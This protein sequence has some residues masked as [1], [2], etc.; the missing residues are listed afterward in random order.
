MADSKPAPLSSLEV[1]TMVSDGR[2]SSTVM[3][4]IEHLD[5]AE[6]R[7]RSVHA[8]PIGAHLEFTVSVHGA[9][10]IPLRGEI[11]AS[12]QNGPRFAYVV[13]LRNA[14]E[15]TEAI[16]KANEAARTRAT[17]QAEVAGIDGLT[18]SSV[19]VPVD[20]VLRYKQLGLGA[21]AAQAINLSTGG[22]HM[23][24]DDEIP[25]GASIDL[26]IPL[27]GQQVALRGRIVAHQ[28]LSPNYNVAFFEVTNEARQNLARFINAA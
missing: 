14:A 9:A 16:A 13:V 17:A 1:P 19:R 5:H 21:R 23:N 26:E 15:N 25:V 10:P 3:A 8:F 22:V 20:F 24:T 27:G 18:R 6:C 4:I 11:A 28:A 7:M 12:K 2:G